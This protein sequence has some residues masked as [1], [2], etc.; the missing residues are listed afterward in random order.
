[1]KIYKI[2]NKING[3][4]YVGQT[5]KS[6]EARWK[7]HQKDSNSHFFCYKF[8][9]AIREF[10]AENFTVEQIDCAA[11]KEEANAKEVFWINFYNAVEEGYNTSPGGKSGG[12]YKKVMNVETG[13]VFDSQKEAAKHYGVNC[14]AIRQAIDKPHRKSAGHHWITLK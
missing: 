9:K 13:Q 10:G 6:L 7:Q 2:T 3:K 8:Q 4:M 11:N 14:E 1:M 12:N 5:K